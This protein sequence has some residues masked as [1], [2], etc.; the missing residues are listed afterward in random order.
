[1]SGIVLPELHEARLPNGLRIAVARRPGVPLA[2]AR[3]AVRAGS[4][5]DP[6]GG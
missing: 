3:L 2:A 5:Q 1:M 6:E 4:A